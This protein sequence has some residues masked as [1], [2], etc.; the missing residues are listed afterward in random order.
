MPEDIKPDKIDSEG[1]IPVELSQ[2][3]DEILETKEDNPESFDL[4]EQ[5][6]QA[7]EEV[8]ED[9]VVDEEIVETEEDIE[10]GTPPDEGEDV[11]PEAEADEGEY[12][13]IDSRLVVAARK[14]G[15][16]DER[17]IELAE[18]NPEILEDIARLVESVEVRDREIPQQ[19]PVE[20]EP[21]K[22]DKVEE[23]IIDAN[24]LQDLKEAF[25]DEAVDKVIAPLINKVQE[26]G[27]Q[28][29]ALR[30]DTEEQTRQK[31][32]DYLVKKYTT[33]NTFFDGASKD[34]PELGESDKLARLTDGKL[35]Q[36][37]PEFQARSRIFSIAETFEQSLGISFDEAL[38]ESMNWHKGRGG[39]KSL[40]RKVIK[41]LNKRK[42]KFS[43]RPTNKHHQKKY[44]N[45]EDKASDVMSD[46]YTE[47]GI[48]D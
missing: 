10:D 39:E 2:K 43:P 17:I 26:Q 13:E 46:I 31:E 15:Y 14:R 25:G 4:T 28:L 11:V 30:G 44:A 1:D 29:N 7:Q 47:L 16:S 45:E 33:A 23:N 37:S 38:K 5:A 3:M 34:F 42:K 41:G 36:T 48:E 18:N 21:V 8:V 32:Y 27:E 35:D 22:E 20:P 19:P 6:E 40:E 12:E 24:A 9:E